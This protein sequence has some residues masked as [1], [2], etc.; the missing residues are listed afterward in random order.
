[1]KKTLLSFALLAGLSAN[2]QLPNG[3]VAP[4]WTF[5]DLDGTSHHL[6]DYLDQ[7]YTVFI[8]VSAAWCGPCWSYHNSHALRDVYEQHGP[9]GSP[10]VDPGTTND[11]MVFFVEGQLNNTAAQLTGTSTGSTQPTFTQ[12]DWVT[13]TTYPILD[14]PNNAAGQ[15]FMNGYSI[16]YFPTIYKICPNRII[17]EIGQEN[18]TTLYAAVAPC[19]IENGTNNAAING[20]LGETSACAGEDVIV[21]LQNMGSANLT[22]ATIE[23]RQGATVLNT[24]TWTGNLATYEMD[25][26]TVGTVSPTGSVNYTVEI[27][28]ADDNTTDNL[29]SQVISEVTAAAVSNFISI[30][31]VTDAYGTETTWALKNSAGATVSSGGPYNDLSAAGTTVQ[32]VVSVTLN[33]SDCYELE[34]YDAYGDGMDAGYGAGYYQVKDAGGNVIVQG[35][36]FTN[37]AANKFK[38]GILGIEEAAVKGLNVYP[39]PASGIVNIDFEGMGGDYE[40]TITDLSGRQ[41]TGVV[42]LAANGSQTVK[43]PVDQ[44][45]SGNYLVTIKAEGIMSTQHVVIK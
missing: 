10:N 11:A 36:A 3:S 25:E 40:V 17:E 35:G 13:G 15:A 42:I 19:P 32:P 44:L 1:M 34:V 28:S 31:I 43:L 26:V 16:A 45:A 22:T 7:G 30:H 39:N 20:Y 6:Y 21:R 14:L 29:F 24:Y 9:V 12:G 23:L 5:T 37:L 8:D 27:T 38:S 2:A 4:D 18:A 41:L 33:P